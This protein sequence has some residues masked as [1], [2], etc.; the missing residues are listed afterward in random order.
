[1]PFFNIFSNKENTQEKKQKIIVDNREKNS[2]VPSELSKLNFNIEFKHLPVA[3]YIINDIAIERKTISDLK[4]SVINK[5]IFTQMLE[6]KQYPLHFLVIEGLNKD[7]FNSGIIHE[8][9]LRGFILSAQIDYNIPLI[10]SENEKET[11][12]Y[13]SILAKR[14]NNK[15]I[16]I[17]AKKISLNK[18]EQLQ[19]ILEGF[20]NI[21]PVKAKALIRK[22]KSLKNIFTASELELEDILGKK[23]KEFKSLLD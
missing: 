14:K 18:K 11:A 1:M 6:L 20:P 2:L 17:R 15:E 16:S 4:S 22:F 10:F 12:L 5:R 13:L 3:D 7:E 23:T 21:G 19:Y 9:A 8:N